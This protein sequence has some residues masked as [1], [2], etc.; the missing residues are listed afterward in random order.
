[1]HEFSFLQSDSC[2]NND[3]VWLLLTVDAPMWFRTKE[4]LLL[5]CSSAPSRAR[6][7]EG[8]PTPAS[9]CW[10]GAARSPRTTAGW[11]SPTSPPP[12]GTGWP[13][14]PSCTI[15]DPTWCKHHQNP[16]AQTQKPP[17][18][19]IEG[20]FLPSS[21]PHSH[22]DDPQTALFSPRFRNRILDL[23]QL[24]LFAGFSTYIEALFQKAFFFCSWFPII[25]IKK[26]RFNI[27][28][29]EKYHN[30]VKNTNNTVFTGVSHK[31]IFLFS[32]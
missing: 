23:V 13:S 29:F 26:W 20:G 4:L 1:M 25:K 21:Q 10:P 7:L 30:N 9:P 32:L 6:F 2:E 27:V 16:G 12:G 3:H 31:N 11:R 15:S 8:N 19:W 17:I 22:R 24:L 18:W 14:A 28:F 5:S